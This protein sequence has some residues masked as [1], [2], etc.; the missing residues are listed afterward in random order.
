MLATALSG[1]SGL[2]HSAVRRCLCF[3]LRL[4]EQL[5]D[6]DAEETSNVNSFNI[7]LAVLKPSSASSLLR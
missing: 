2:A 1:S 3:G 4:Q 6:E 5:T 7:D